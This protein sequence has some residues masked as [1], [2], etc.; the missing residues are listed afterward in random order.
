[1]PSKDERPEVVPVIIATIVAIMSAGWL[2][3]DLKNDAPNTGDDVITSAVVVASWRDDHSVGPSGS[4]GSAADGCL[5]SG[6]PRL[7]V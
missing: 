7:A 2:W 1:M 4:S 3:F 6:R 5:P